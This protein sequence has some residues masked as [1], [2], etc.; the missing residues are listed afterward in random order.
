[1]LTKEQY[2]EYLSKLYEEFLPD[3]KQMVKDLSKDVENKISRV[4]DTHSK[5]IIVNNIIMDLC[6]S[7]FIV[8]ILKIEEFSKLDIAIICDSIKENIL[9][10]Y[11]D[12]NCY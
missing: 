2:V 8:Y 5:D 11:D 3:F 6:L 9:D 4:F 10:I 12:E 1:M 7:G